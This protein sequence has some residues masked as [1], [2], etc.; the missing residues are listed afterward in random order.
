M[1]SQYTN[2]FIVGIKGVAMA[3]I[4]RILVQLGKNVSGSDVSEEFITDQELQDI[5]IVSSFEADALPQE[6]DLVIYSAAHSGLQNKQVQEALSRNITVIHQAE[7]IGQLLTL[8]RTSVAI[9]G[10]HGKTT[11]SSLLAYALKKLG[12]RPGFL[13]GVSE[14]NGIPG[15]DVGKNDYFV[16]EADE[17]A[18]NPPLD[19]TPKFHKFHPT[20]ALITNID[21]DHPD[22]FDNIGQ[23][24]QAFE[25][26][27]KQ[28]KSQ[29]EY[30]KPHIVLCSEDQQVKKVASSLVR[31]TYIT[32]GFAQ[33]SDV[34][35]SQLT[36]IEEGM[37]F[38]VKSTLLEINDEFTISLYG[39][40]NVLNAVGAISLLRLLG[41]SLSQ[42]QIAIES[43]TGAK[44][45][46]EFVYCEDDT[47]VF[48]DYAH[49]PQEIES[50]IQAAR[51]RFPDRRIVIIFQPHTFT[52][53]Q[54][55]QKEFVHALSNA[56]LS[57]IAP[58]FGSAREIISDGAITS[59]D[60]EV[61]AHEENSNNIKG[62]NAT[63]DLIRSLS[64]H[65]QKKDVIFTMGAGDIYKLAKPLREIIKKI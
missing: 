39:E 51:V 17:Y 32:Y 64:H 7:F 13:V 24:E 33:E 15:G 56:D 46:F 4:A 37:K 28:V 31:D 23:T 12:V 19:K 54:S 50:T 59:V 21:F 35:V 16:F 61:L 62:Y 52:R 36:T 57:I 1:V 58:I 53:T 40:K 49:H 14:F 26:F 22:V 10:C 29:G 42:I 2:I 60:L 20:H 34:I 45:R 63:E 18:M 30:T 25:V 44:R 8:Y 9:A 38:T 41:F 43:F 48:D 55:L 65:I 3:N 27:L 6:T 47:Y 11:T 5:T